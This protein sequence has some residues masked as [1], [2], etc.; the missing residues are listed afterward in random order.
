MAQ[1]DVFITYSS[2]R[3][4]GKEIRNNKVRVKAKVRVRVRARTRVRARVEAK[5]RKKEEKK[6]LLD[7]T[8]HLSLLVVAV[9]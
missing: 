3:E 4:E 7:Q 9:T 6:L 5:T 1:W 2:N 8:F